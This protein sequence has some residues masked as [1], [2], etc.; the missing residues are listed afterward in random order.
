MIRER[1]N[2]SECDRIAEQTAQPRLSIT[3]FLYR[4]SLSRFR[5]SGN[6]EW[7]LWCRAK[8][9]AAHRRGNGPGRARNASHWRITATVLVRVIPNGSRKTALKFNAQQL[10]RKASR[11]DSAGIYLDLAGFW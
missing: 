7:T 8:Q 9:R 1:L 4:A 3:I 11:L 6:V 10:A 5:N 2:D